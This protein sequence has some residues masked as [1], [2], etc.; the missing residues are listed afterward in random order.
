MGSCP[1][2][3]LIS[4]GTEHTINCSHTESNI[5]EHS[6][7]IPI[8]ALTQLVPGSEIHIKVFISPSIYLLNRLEVVTIR[9]RKA[10]GVI[11]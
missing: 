5:P 1:R 9:K 8:L 10:P 3:L 4:V 11:L 6:I 2:H 7:F